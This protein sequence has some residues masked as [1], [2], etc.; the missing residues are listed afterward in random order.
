MSVI[1][2]SWNWCPEVFSNEVDFKRHFRL[3]HLTSLTFVKGKDWDDWL[4]AET[5]RADKSD[6]L[7]D[8]IPTQTLTSLSEPSHSYEVVSPR[9]LSPS[10]Q[11][12][13]ISASSI[14][15]TPE[16][17]PPSRKRSFSEFNDQSSPTPP[18]EPMSPSPL[19]SN[20]I[21][22][23]TNPR[24]T[25]LSTPASPVVSIA[26]GHPI[27]P[28]NLSRESSVSA[29]DVETQ[30]QL[31]SPAQSSTDTPPEQINSEGDHLP[32]STHNQ[33]EVNLFSKPQPTSPAR[34]MSPIRSL[35]RSPSPPKIRRS[36]R[37]RSQTPVPVPAPVTNG[38][39][40]RANSTAGSVTSRPSSRRRTPT[41]RQSSV[42]PVN[43]PTKKRKVARMP[44]VPEPAIERIPEEP[45]SFINHPILGEVQVLGT[46]SNSFRINNGEDAS[47][48]SSPEVDELADDA[49]PQEPFLDTTSIG[50]DYGFSQLPLQTQ[51]P[52][53]SQ[54]DSQSQ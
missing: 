19:L 17:S 8:A 51:A 26:D 6:S 39:R 7:L 36:S 47:R 23:A 16:P 32:I 12:P 49:P 45:E 28:G 4:K 53:F 10:R 48:S 29:Q 14:P 54:S 44:F 20:M 2:C 33:K 38:R 18:I 24:S 46:H 25:R 52:Y 3:V 31:L 30:L 37:T 42:E 21:A 43:P 11:N 35:P 41:S 22:D 5:G 1:A 9:G 50:Y 40:T 34:P 27:S 13:S 15:N